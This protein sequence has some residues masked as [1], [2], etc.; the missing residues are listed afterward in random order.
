MYFRGFEGPKNIINKVDCGIDSQPAKRA[1]LEEEIC[2]GAKGAF[3]LPSW[4]WRET[5]L[6]WT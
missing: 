2:P 1:V 6:Q 5:L 3:I 4:R